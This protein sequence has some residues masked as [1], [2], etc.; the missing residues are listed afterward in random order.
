[1]FHSY[2]VVTITPKK[3]LTNTR[4]SW[5]FSSDG[6]F[7]V[8]LTATWHIRLHGHRRG[9]VIT[10]FVDELLVVVTTCFVNEVCRNQG[11]NHDLPHARRLRYQLS[12][13]N[14]QYSK[15]CAA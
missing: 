7:L 12:N 8:K 3:N 5:S 1:M 14:L 13:G 4:H 6:P 15:Y 2:V 9:I 10:T 11:S